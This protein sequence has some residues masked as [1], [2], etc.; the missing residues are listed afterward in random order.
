MT[1]RTHRSLGLIALVAVLVLAVPG[2]AQYREYY[3]TGNVIDT[4]KNPVAGAEISLRDVKTSR[5]YNIKTDKKGEFKFAGLPHGVYAVEIRKEGFALKQDE[6]RFETP[7]DTMQRVEIPAI[8]IV[9]QVQVEEIQK[10]KEAESG[11]KEAAD[12]I[13]NDDADGAIAKL[14]DLLAT[15]P[16]EPN[17]LYLLGIAYAKK[18]MHAEAQAAFLQVTELAPKFAAAFYHLGVAYQALDQPEKALE[19]YVRTNELDPANADALLQLRPRPVQAEPHR[20]SPDRVREGHRAQARR[21]G[22]SGDGRPLLHQQGRFRKGHRVPR[23]GQGRLQRRRPVEI[24]RRADRTAEAPD[25]EIG[26]PAMSFTSLSAF[27]MT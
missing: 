20:R 22:V 3:I 1:K 14:K 4:Q 9:S 5:G 27:L 23:K 10:L 21:S 13:R 17:S 6:W 11:V 8:T 24:P 15:N 2:L 12:L 16:K 7:Q 25:Q 19:A 18:S 26:R